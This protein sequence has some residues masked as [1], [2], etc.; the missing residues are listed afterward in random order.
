MSAT[1]PAPLPRTGARP[2]PRFQPR[3]PPAAPRSWSQ[4]VRL[5]DIDLDDQRFQH[6]VVVSSADLVESLRTQGQHTP[7]I[8]WGKEPPY[9]VID[10]FRR[11]GAISELGGETVEA[12]I[13]WTLDEQEAY[14]RAFSEN[15]RRRSLSAYDR[16]HAI[17]RALQRWVL[18]KRE[19][20]SLLALS[21]RQIDRYLA[22]LAF[23]PSLQTALAE[24]RISMAQAVV[25]HR[26]A[27]DGLER[28]IEE[29]AS[30]GISAADLTRRLRRTRP[31]RRRAYLVRD[32]RGFRLRAVR[33]RADMSPTEKRRIW[34][35]LETALRVMAHS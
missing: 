21:V 19:L 6:R 1:T 3:R 28:W 2:L 22:L 30:S 24:E 10:G 14:A 27:P 15:V 5:G 8:L 32:P 25:L 17:H 11:I 35:A 31:S 33:Y 7:V 13:E 16:G 29:V 4:T 20:A 18:D 26:C 9:I 23:D 34:D 12:V